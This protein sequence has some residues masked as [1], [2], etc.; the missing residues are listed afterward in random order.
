M[1]RIAYRL[2]KWLLARDLTLQERNLFTNLILDKVDAAP[3][4]AILQT[5]D[6]GSI[7]VNGSPIDMEMAHVLHAAANS[8]LDNKAEKLIKEQVLWL[9]IVNGF[10]N[11]DSPEKLHFFRAAIWWEQQRE[12]ILHLLSARD[13]SYSSS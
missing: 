10:H 6:D 9:A 2:L 8:A 1:V 5:E 11:G 7:I 13:I 12:K 4:Y 3:L